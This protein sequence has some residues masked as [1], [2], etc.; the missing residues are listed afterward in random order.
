MTSAAFNDGDVVAA[1]PEFTVHVPSLGGG[2]KRVY[3][4]ADG[5]ID[6]ALKVAL[7][8]TSAADD[9][10]EIGTQRF[11]REIAAMKATS[12]PHVVTLLRGPETRSVGGA[13][14]FWYTEPFLEGGTL[15]ARLKNGPL[16][17]DDVCNLAQALLTA[18]DAMWNEGHFV[19]RDINPANIGYLADG[20]IV[21]IDLGVALF[22][23]L[24][25]LT[26]SHINSPGT[27]KYAAPEQFEMRRLA[28]IDFRTDL[29]QIGIVLV[30]ALV[31]P[32][33]R[34]RRVP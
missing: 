21:L 33:Q 13:D 26:E 8:P 32:A 19:H 5:S 2:Q 6:V 4:A 29:F 28:T 31:G 17:V 30:E 10:V 23:E 3:R 15:R 20:T 24:S 1:F 18:V 7:H 16:S 12:C 11:H 9:E 25:P 14:R 34:V 22:T 27:A